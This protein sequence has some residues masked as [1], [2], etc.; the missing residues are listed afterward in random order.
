MPAERVPR[1]FLSPRQVG[2]SVE[3]WYVNSAVT[4]GAALATVAGTAAT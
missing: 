3:R 2:T 1:T 4:G